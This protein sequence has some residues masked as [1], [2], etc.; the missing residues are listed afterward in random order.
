MIHHWLAERSIAM[1]KKAE[2]LLGDFQGEL[3]W[4]DDLMKWEV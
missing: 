1:T 4:D 3:P 2:G